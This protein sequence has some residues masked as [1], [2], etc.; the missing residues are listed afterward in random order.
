[1]GMGQWVWGSGNGAV[2]M[3][4]WECAVGM[5]LIGNY[6]KELGTTDLEIIFIMPFTFIT[7]YLNGKVTIGLRGNYP[8]IRIKKIYT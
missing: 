2:G 6:K 5:G 8:M 3:E 4:Q 7:R 1:M